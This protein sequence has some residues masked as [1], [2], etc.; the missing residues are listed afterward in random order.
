MYWS[1]MKITNQVLKAYDGSDLEV[2]G[3]KSELKNV[4]LNCLAYEDKD[5]KMTAEE[6]MRAFELSMDLYKNNEADFKV[7][8]IVFIKQRLLKITSPLLYG[9]VCNILEPKDKA[10]G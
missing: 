5:L 10:N 3:K 8:D 1:S 7:E 9:Q 6:K 4:L 2:E